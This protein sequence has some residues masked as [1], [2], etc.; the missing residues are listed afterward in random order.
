MCNYEV[1]PLSN[2]PK[3]I[4]AWITDL[5]S[6]AKWPLMHPVEALLFYSAVFL[7]SCSRKIVS[8]LSSIH[9]LFDTWLLVL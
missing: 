1:I 9:S 4:I 6:I 8:S 3:D 7:T 5:A 2:D